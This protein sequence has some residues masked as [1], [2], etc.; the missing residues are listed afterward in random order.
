M[1]NV[2]MRKGFLTCTKKVLVSYLIILAIVAYFYSGQAEAA[3]G[4]EAKVASS[5][6]YESLYSKARS[7]GSVKVIVKVHAPFTPEVLLQA[8]DGHAQRASR[9]H[10]QDQIITELES[11]GHKPRRI[12]KYKYSPYIAMTVDSTTLDALLSSQNVIGVEEDI[13]VWPVLGQSVPRI[14]AA[15]LHESNVTGAGVAVAILDTGVDKTH[16]FL[17]GS[18]VSEACYSTDDPLQGSSSLCPGN[19][20]TSTEDDSAMPCGGTY[21]SDEC[22][23]GTHVAGIVAGRDNISGS[24]GP[25]VAPESKIIAIQVF[26][27]IDGGLGAFSSDIK[28]GLERVIDL[29]NDYLI[30]SVNMSLGSGLHANPCDVLDESYGET[31]LK[32]SI[33]LLQDAL[34]QDAGIATVVAS[35]N[36]G[37]CGAISYP[38]CISSAISVGATDDNDAVAGFSNSA[39]FLS[40]LAPGQWITSSVPGGGYEPWRGTS[41]A[42]PHVAGAWALMKQAYPAAT[43]NDILNA[44][45]STGLS[46]TDQGCTSVT[47]KRINVY[48]AYSL[49][50]GKT[51]LIVSKTGVGT[52]TVTSDLTGIDCGSTCNFW[53]SSDTVAVTLNASADPGS[54]FGGWSGGGCSGTNECTVSLSAGTSVT[55]LFRKQATIGT[56]ITIKGSGFGNKKGK[57][58]IGDV[59]AKI[60]KDAWTHDTITCTVNKIPDGSPGIFDLTIISKEADSIL[61][62]DTIDVKDPEIFDSDYHG[63]A[64]GSIFINGWFFGTKKP[65]AYLEYPEEN[66]GT[67]M[68]KCKVASWFMNTTTGESNLVFVVP[69]GLVPGSYTLKVSNKVG[70][71]VPILFTLN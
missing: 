21:S 26:S 51:N 53:F 2:I 13:V 43:V 30:A 24:P 16:P 39:S 55:A 11:K 61:I 59:A 62:Q 45:T 44:F 41:M 29:R 68:K 33:D 18:V 8:P 1:E 6:R 35:G 5:G 25:G 34:L 63:V 40:L 37:Y 60:A 28:K 3:N 47:K 46:V 70:T 67:K 32:T 19:V 10:I 23:H 66:G 64:G 42:S 49:L 71:S 14:G 4:N 58:L 52:G 9:L 27:L 17:S 57:V 20:G 15:E 22:D 54:E 36:D 56:Q 7:K 50:S 48:E 69:K 31:A 12:H 38:A 65:K